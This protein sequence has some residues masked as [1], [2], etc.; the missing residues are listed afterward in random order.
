MRIK[1][2]GLFVVLA[3]LL[4]GTMFAIGAPTVSLDNVTVSPG[5]TSIALDLW[6]L[7]DSSNPVDS[8]TFTFG[9][10]PSGFNISGVTVYPPTNWGSTVALPKFGATDYGYP[11]NPIVSDTK[12][13]TL[14]F[15]FAADF[16]QVTKQVNVEFS[17]LEL[18]D[19]QGYSYQAD[20]VVVQGGKVSSVPIP[21]TALLFLSGIFGL[22]GIRRFRGRKLEG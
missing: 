13:A 22:V 5:D 17:F 7:T 1:T 21:A 3:F 16:F 18:S 8:A 11:A 9:S 19:D 6:I 4:Q 14:T 15:D 20:Q 10:L 12:F 2:L